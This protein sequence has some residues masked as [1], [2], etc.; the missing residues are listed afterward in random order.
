MTREFNEV[1]NLLE[2][3]RPPEMFS[4]DDIITV[5]TGQRYIVV[6]TGPHLVTNGGLMLHDLSRRT[7]ANARRITALPANS[8]GYMNGVGYIVDP[9]AIGALSATADLG[10]DGLIYAPVTGEAA[11]YVEQS[12]QW[13]VNPVD[14]PVVYPA[15]YS[16][17]HWATKAREAAETV[18]KWRSEWLPDTDYSEGDRVKYDGL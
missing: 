11:V 8:V 14:T 10:V 2:D 9:S 1:S 17:F 13:A 12:R 3:T 5:R 16:S 6:D 15:Q 7:E 18:G 4:N